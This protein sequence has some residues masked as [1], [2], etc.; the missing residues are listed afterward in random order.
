MA[1]LNAS[2]SCLPTASDETYLTREQLRYLQE[3]LLN[4][5]TRLCRKLS[6][7]LGDAPAQSLPDWVDSASH[8]TQSE[9][10][11]ADRERTMLLIKQIDAALER[12]ASGTYG[13]CSE[14]G[15]EIGIQRL[16]A[17]PTAE[18]CID[19]Q[20]EIERRNKRFR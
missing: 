12:M 5:R 20:Q 17:L 6:G 15:E 8:N 11:W 19:T 14:S 10:T 9:L 18:Y 1:E 13:Y 16:M 7:R 2:P 4:W 3:T